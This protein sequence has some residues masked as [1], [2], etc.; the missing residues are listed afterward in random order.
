MKYPSPAMAISL[1]ALTVA[2]GGTGYA[3]SQLPEN[4]VGTAQLANGAVTSDKV[5][6]GTLEGRKLA[7]RSVTAVK[8]ANGAVTGKAV[9]NGS[10]TAADFT[11]GTLARLGGRRGPAGPQGVAGPKGDTGATGA[12]GP[13]GAT[14]PAGPQGD[15]GPQGPAGTPMVTAQAWLPYEVFLDATTVVLDTGSVTLPVQSR[16]FAWTSVNLVREPGS[17]NVITQGG[18]RLAY[19]QPPN[20]TRLNMATGPGNM[21]MPQLAASAFTSAGVAMTANQV[22]APGTYSFVVTC[23]RYAG[24]VDSLRANEGSLSVFAIPT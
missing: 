2:L 19:T 3:V 16:V 7:N 5:K 4:S 22:L 6:D 15:P 12:Q 14:G 9:K 10:L 23:E 17:Y 21:I 8:I 11:P 13:A 20:A 24:N 18:C 1:A